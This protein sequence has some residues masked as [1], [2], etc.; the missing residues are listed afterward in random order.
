MENTPS[1]NAFIRSVPR[2]RRPSCVF[3]SSGIAI[4]SDRSTGQT[5]WR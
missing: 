3:P 2:N 5:L 4:S 1:L